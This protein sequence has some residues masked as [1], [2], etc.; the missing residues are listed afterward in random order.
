MLTRSFVDDDYNDHG[1]YVGPTA[2]SSV[3]RSIGF[4]SCIVVVASILAVL[5]Y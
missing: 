5:L 1:E 3:F 4:W 2:G